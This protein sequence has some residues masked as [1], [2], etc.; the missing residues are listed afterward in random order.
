[1]RPTT[2]ASTAVTAVV[3]NPNPTTMYT[4][5]GYTDEDPCKQRPIKYFKKK[6]DALNYVEIDG[7]ATS[8]E[9]DSGK[10]IWT[11]DES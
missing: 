8:I 7:M 11:F 5:F 2:K 6:Q 9:D 3:L 1:M 4:V 10:E